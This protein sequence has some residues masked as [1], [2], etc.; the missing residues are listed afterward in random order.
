MKNFILHNYPSIDTYY[1][2][3]RTTVIDFNLQTKVVCI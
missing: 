1:Y 2:Y 3:K